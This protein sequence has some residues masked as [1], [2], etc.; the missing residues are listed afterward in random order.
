[1]RKKKN[2]LGFVPKKT[3]VPSSKI[4]NL[5]KKIDKNLIFSTKN[6]IKKFINS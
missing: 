5:K 3:S 6:V 4:L 1:M 2:I